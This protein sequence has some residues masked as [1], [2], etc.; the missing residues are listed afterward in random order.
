MRVWLRTHSTPRAQLPE[1]RPRR[2]GGRED[3]SHLRFAEPPAA[4]RGAVSGSPDPCEAQAASGGPGSRVRPAPRAPRPPRSVQDT[5]SPA[6]VTSVRQP[7]CLGAAVTAPQNGP[8]HGGGVTGASGG[9]RPV[10]PRWPWVRRG[11]PPSSL[12]GAARAGGGTP[13]GGPH[14]CCPG[15]ARRVG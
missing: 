13:R 10:W 12:G 3:E 9:A 11:C 7:V 15:T 5:A 2:R 1:P 6:A 14:G 8:E 4:E